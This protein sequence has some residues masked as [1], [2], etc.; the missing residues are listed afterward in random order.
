MQV[1]W[2]VAQPRAEGVKCLLTAGD[3]VLLVRHT[4]GR[5]VWDLPGGGVKRSEEPLAAARREMEEELGLRDAA[6]RPAGIVRGRQ[7]H[8]HDLVHC[9][10][11]ELRSEDV[12]PNL[13]ELAEVGWFDRRAVPDR[14]GPYVRPVLD[15]ALGPTDA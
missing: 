6:W 11:A 4:Y 3:R 14:T 10:Q 9:F 7:N 8:R 13:A 1:F 2:F 5:R 12:E 15:G